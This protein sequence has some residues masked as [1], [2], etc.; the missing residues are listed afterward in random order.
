MRVAEC[1]PRV[2]RADSNAVSPDSGVRR[3]ERK[4]WAPYLSG[5][6]YGAFKRGHDS[7][8]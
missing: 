7:F 5:K 3:G 2:A 6:R 4:K 1:G 8:H